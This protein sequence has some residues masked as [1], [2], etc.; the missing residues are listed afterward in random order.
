MSVWKLVTILSLIASQSALAQTIAPRLERRLQSSRPDET[1]LVWIYLMDKGDAS[2]RLADARRQVSSRAFERRAKRGAGAAVQYDDIPPLPAYVR[3][4]RERVDRV[5]HVSSW[6]NAVSAEATSDQ[7]AELARLPFV[8]QLDAVGRFTKRAEEPTVSTR[9]GTPLRTDSSA[10][11]PNYGSSF[12][13]LEQLNV[14]ALHDLGLTGA[15]VVIAVFDTGFKNLRH[16]ALSHLSILTR[17]D[18]VNGDSAVGN[19]QDRGDGSHGGIV[20]SV[21]GGYA[22]GELIGPAF[23]A[24]FILAKTENTASETPVEE[25]N[26]AAAA[27]WAEAWGAD[28]ITSSLGYLG[29]DA[30]FDGYTYLDMDG[31][32]AVTTRAAQMAAERGV[33]VVTSAGNGGFQV[34]RNTLGAPADGALVLSIG[35]VDSFGLRADFSSVGRTA[36]GRIKPDVMAQGVLVKG[37]DPDS[38]GYVLADGTSFACPLSAGV[39]AL[40]LEAHPEWTVERV[41]AALRSTASNAWAPTRLTGWGIVDGLAALGSR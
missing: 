3:A 32:T 2:A 25:D 37:I 12:G 14:P 9:R 20:L 18:F 34:D 7:I 10:A 30:P 26:W 36:D 28:V 31:K 24:T 33:V 23:G 39:V 41:R 5:R 11:A 40:L 4:I 38:A 21:V 1:Q 35:A 27:E 17:W 22:P 29:F 16:E 6:F 8:T 19:N 15:G 13:Q